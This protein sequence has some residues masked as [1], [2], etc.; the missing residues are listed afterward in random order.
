MNIH[1]KKY[2][3]AIQVYNSE[4]GKMQIRIEISDQVLDMQNKYNHTRNLINT[5]LQYQFFFYLI[6]SPC[7][8][9]Y[10]P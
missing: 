1:L 9:Y 4:K 2:R 3:N 10:T 7:F 8:V 6:I 5:H